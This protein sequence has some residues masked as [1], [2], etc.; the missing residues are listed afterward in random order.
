[1]AAE[2]ADGADK[3]DRGFAPAHH[4]DQ[5]TEQRRPHQVGGR[6]PVHHERQAPV[7][8][9]HA[10]PDPQQH[11]EQPR[12]DRVEPGEVQHH[13]GPP[14]A[15]AVEDGSLHGTRVAEGEATLEGEHLRPGSV[16][17]GM[18]RERTRVMH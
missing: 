3:S 11:A 14:R 6:G 10:P 9:G 8:A 7:N 16:R 17:H 5:A 13:P 12:A 4:V 15:D 1:M 2:A 18:Q